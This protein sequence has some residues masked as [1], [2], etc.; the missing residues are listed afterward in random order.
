MLVTSQSLPRYRPRCCQSPVPSTRQLVA[1]ALVPQALAEAIEA[2]A[3]AW[4]CQWGS[5]D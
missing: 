4:R 1:L 5:K 2:C 3:Q